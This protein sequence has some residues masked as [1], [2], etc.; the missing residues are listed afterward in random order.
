MAMNLRTIVVDAV[1]SCDPVWS[2]NIED[3]NEV[4]LMMT[5]KTTTDNRQTNA[6]N[7][8]K[9]RND[10]DDDDDDEIIDSRCLCGAEV[11]GCA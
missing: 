10:N 5:T 11:R 2:R 9:M 4:G 1:V 3:A 6:E 8:T 7:E